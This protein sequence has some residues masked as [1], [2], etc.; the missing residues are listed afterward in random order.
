MSILPENQTGTWRTWKLPSPA[1]LPKGQRS[2]QLQAMAFGE[3]VGGGRKT[4]HPG[5][6]WTGLSCLWGGSGR[7][8]NPQG[9]SACFFK[10]EIDEEKPSP[11]PMTAHRP[12]AAPSLYSNL[13]P[14]AFLNTLFN[15]YIISM[16]VTRPPPLCHLSLSRS[17][18]VILFL[19]GFETWHAERENNTAFP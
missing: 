5:G 4:K 7:R 9:L 8:L 18:Y 2:R 15:P 6:N 13:L 17:L 10:Y 14:P 11:S 12:Q 16:G 19:P 3:Q 1:H